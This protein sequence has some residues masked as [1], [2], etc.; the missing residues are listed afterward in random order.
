MAASALQMR[1]SP[2]HYNRQTQ[3]D[4]WQKRPVGIAE[5]GGSS[6]PAGRSTPGSTMADTT[7]ISAAARIRCKEDRVS[8]HAPVGTCGSDSAAHRHPCALCTACTGLDGTT[9]KPI[10]ASAWRISVAAIEPACVPD[11][12]TGPERNDGD[13]AAACSEDVPQQPWPTGD[14][15]R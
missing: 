12:A 15:D 7:P 11:A 4:V 8:G 1:A 6:N 5:P 14:S 3:K 9:R 13:G 10:T 2:T